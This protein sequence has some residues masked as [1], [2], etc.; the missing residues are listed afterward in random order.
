VASK[1]LLSV[2]GLTKK[3][4]GLV[5]VNNVSFD[6]R[7]GEFLGLIGPNGAGKT[8]TFNLICGFLKPDS[9][10]IVFMGKDITG[11][12]PHEVAKA[13]IGR[14][15]QIV[16][17]FLNFTVLDNVVAAA[18]MRADSVGEAREKALKHLEFVGLY[19]KRNWK[20]KSLNI[21]Q[22]KRLELAKA[23]AL[24]PKLL[25]L[26]EAVAGLNPTEVDTL[27]ELLKE[28][29]SSGKTILMVEHVMRAV[30]SISQ[31]IIVL[32]HGSIISEGT[33]KEVAN[34]PKVIEAYLGAKRV[35]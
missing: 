13:G 33:P 32:H 17:P 34:D 35:M 6:V 28:I 15:F 25:L 2:R 10:R 5:A 12:P 11:K 29:H 8:T 20:A 31:R 4:G 16:R 9:G 30:M 1:S 27:L 19:D 3:F 14:T 21:A 23:L 26:D 22:R 24:E 7:D 18:L